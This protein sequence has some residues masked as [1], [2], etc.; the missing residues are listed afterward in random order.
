MRTGLRTRR[1]RVGAT[2]LLAGALAAGGIATA[3]AAWVDQNCSGGSYEM[4]NWKRSQASTYFEPMNHEGYE[5]GGGCFKLNDRDDTPG[6]RDS[7]GEGTDCSGLVFRT[8]ALK[9]DRSMGYR[10]WDYNKDI[11]GPYSTADY[12]WPGASEPFKPVVKGYGATYAM[13][14]FVYRNT[15]NTAGHIGLI[16]L[17]ATGGTDYIAESAGDDDGTWIQLRDYRAQS[18]YRGVQRKD[19]TPECFPRCD[20]AATDGE[21]P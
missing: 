18:S 2:A 16:Y 12:Y 8:W 15:G 13:D 19:W 17:E 4:L 9:N 1:L 5:W 3:H 20:P 10:H 14:A 6:A 11:H 7:G 21:R